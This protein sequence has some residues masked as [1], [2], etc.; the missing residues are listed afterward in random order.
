NLFR[1]GFL[2]GYGLN[3]D[4]RH[5]NVG[6]HSG[7]RLAENDLTAMS[8]VFFL[9]EQHYVSERL[10]VVAGVQL[11]RVELELDDEF[12]G[13]DHSGEEVFRAVNPKAGLRYE[14]TGDAQLYGNASRSFEPP[15]F[16]E[17]AQ[18]A[19]GGLSFPRA[20][21]AWTFE[22]GTRGRSGVVAWDLSLYWAQV[23]GELLALVD[24]L[25]NP[26]GT[27][28]ADDTL[29]R[30]VEMAVDVALF[31][32]PRPPAAAQTGPT[33]VLVRQSY[34]L[35]DFRFDDDPVYGRNALAGLPRHLYRLE[36]RF[37]HE[38]GFYAAP[39]AEWASDWHV[40]HTNTYEANGYGT[41]GIQI[42]YRTRTFTVF[43]EGRNL[44]DRVYSPTT[45]VIAD[46]GGAS[47]AVFNAA[48]ERSG[49]AGIE[50]RW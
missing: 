18:N 7:A 9:E 32:G 10:A 21:S 28:N 30:G 3:A 25:G 15:S 50:Y 12:P 35:N 11:A 20:Q 26:L 5:A 29:H 8:L 44:A 24:A 46:A 31:E 40:D 27:A 6:G 4:D 42:G 2:P 23:D 19:A 45:G 41:F 22:I 36:L 48:D 47:P 34:M 13:V 37:E 1:M 39:N 49:Y 38:L 14:L 16:G 17:I 33:R 43:V